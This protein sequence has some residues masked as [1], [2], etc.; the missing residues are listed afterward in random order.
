MMD[1]HIVKAGPNSG[2][3][4]SIL[5]EESKEPDVSDYN[6]VPFDTGHK[7]DE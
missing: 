6:I 4:R 5:N 7:E 1:D 2:H 3:S